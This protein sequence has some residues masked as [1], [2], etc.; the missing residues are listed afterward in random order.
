MTDDPRA[1]QP[2][3]VGPVLPDPAD[4]GSGR[5][6]TAGPGPAPAAGELPDPRREWLVRDFLWAMLAGLAGAF[7]VGVVAGVVQAARAGLGAL[8]EDLGGLVAATTVGQYA[9]HGIALALLARRRRGGFRALRLV[10]RPTDGLYVFAGVGLQFLVAL[11]FAPL[12]RTLGESPQALT[13]MLPDIGGTV[14]RTVLIVAIGF[15]APLVEEVLFRGILYRAFERRWGVGAA[16]G[17]SAIIFSIFHLF[18]VASSDPL[19][20]AAVLIPQIFVVG[21]VFAWLVR[22]HDRLGVSIFAHAGFNLVAVVA[23]FLAPDLLP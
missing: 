8:T 1:D 21:L 18:G 13:E 20:A 3:P 22:R 14:A 7:A 4:P 16:M 11:A 2:P 12:T 17:G 5:P 10:V 9:G 15:A 6:G 23:L 19:R